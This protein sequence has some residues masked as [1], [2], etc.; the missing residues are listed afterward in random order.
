MSFQSRNFFIPLLRFKGSVEAMLSQKSF[1]NK[2]E[3]YHFQQNHGFMSRASLKV[4]ENKSMNHL[5]I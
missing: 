3:Y 4:T 5:I 2:C 1:G